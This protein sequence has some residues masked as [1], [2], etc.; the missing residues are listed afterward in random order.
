[1]FNAAAKIINPNKKPVDVY[2]DLKKII[3]QQTVFF[4]APE[5][6]WNRSDNI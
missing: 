4:P 2:N 1:M 6:R 5:K 3:P